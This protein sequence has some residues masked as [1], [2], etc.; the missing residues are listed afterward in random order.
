MEIRKIS[1]AEYFR[2]NVIVYWALILGVI[3]ANAVIVFMFLNET[4]DNMFAEINFPVAAIALGVTIVSIFLSR[5]LFR[6]RMEAIQ[7]LTKLAEKMS[8]YKA[9]LMIKYALIEFP[10]FVCIILFAISNEVL[11]MGIALVIIGYY[12]SE[13]PTRLKCYA[14]L[15][16]DE[17]EKMQLDNPEGR[18][19]EMNVQ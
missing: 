3:M 11:I 2:T 4:I 7:V 8:A 17:K 19:C 5:M 6:K 12:L 1:N 16:L 18:I 13:R 10:A 14:D 15:C 9:A